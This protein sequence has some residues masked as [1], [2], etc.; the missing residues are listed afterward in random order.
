MSITMKGI[1]APVVTP[2]NSDGSV[3][4][5]E[6]ESICKFVTEQ[7]VHGLF[8]TGTTGEFINLTLDERKKLLSV[9]RRA[10]SDT[11]TIMF[12]T[13][14]MNKYDIADLCT[15]GKNEGADAFSF[16]APYY[17]KYDAAALLS[18]FKECSELAGNT[19]VFLYNMS[20]MT[21]NPISPELLKN[22]V[23][24]CPNVKGVK[25]S[26]MDFMN[27]LEYKS[28]I[29]NDSFE[30]I[31]GNDAQVFSTLQAGGS[32]GLIALA[33]IF[34]K[35]SAEI[36]NS[37]IQGDLKKAEAA[38]NTIM[39]LRGICRKVMPIMSHKAMLALQGFD[40]GPARFPLRDLRQD[41]IDLIAKEVKNLGI[42]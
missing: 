1:S 40:L 39:A 10:V 35:I 24:S 21:G 7:G 32:G 25:D 8:V 16:T 13:T 18:Y 30:I 20:T 3:N 5:S 11:T 23:D 15:W 28:I 14:A 17:H 9:A 27:I 29:N 22:V 36:Y 41:E 38:Q 2:M 31:T 19:P 6:F 34:P 4:Y 12:N 26:S 33:G 42:L 37:F